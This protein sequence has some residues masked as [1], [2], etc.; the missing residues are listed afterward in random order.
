MRWRDK[1][2]C[3]VA[4]KRTRESSR[5][6]LPCDPSSVAATNAVVHAQSSF[7]VTVETLPSDGVRVE[8][9][10]FGPGTPQLLDDGPIAVKGRGLRIASVLAEGW[11]V[12]DRPG[13]AGTSTW[14]TLN[15]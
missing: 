14:F 6:L 3:L 13:G 4:D 8:V 7:D 9:R 5:T 15:A 10:D 1:A 11:G 2:C 12:Q